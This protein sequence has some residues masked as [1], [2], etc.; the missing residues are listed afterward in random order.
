M[1]GR[2]LCFLGLHAWGPEVSAHR[3]RY[4]EC[5]RCGLRWWR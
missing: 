5:Q 2:L 1:L 3:W 4:R